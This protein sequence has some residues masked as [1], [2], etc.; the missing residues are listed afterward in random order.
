MKKY[1]VFRLLVV[2]VAALGLFAA[3][4]GSD[5]G[6]SRSN[7]GSV[8]VTNGSIY[9]IT[10]LYITL[11]SDPSW[12]SNRI[13]TSITSGSTRTISGLSPGTYDLWAVFSNGEDYEQY[14]FTV[15]S[16][17]T[18]PIT[19]T[20][21][22]GIN[23]G[24]V[25]V[26]NG[27]STYAITELYISPSSSS[28]WG[29]NQISSS[30]AVGSTRTI[31]GIPV[32]TYDLQAVFS[33][34]QTYTLTGFSVTANQTFAVTA[35]HSSTGGS[36]GTIT[37]RVIDALSRTALSNASY[38]VKQGTTT[39]ASGTTGSDGS[40]TAT[41]SA[42]TGYSVTITRTGYAQVV[43]SNITAEAGY[44]TYVEDI[45]QI[46]NTYATGTGTISGTISNAFDGTG[47]SGLTV[48]CVRA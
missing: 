32:G 23:T 45:P 34:A 48:G 28:T 3:G 26:T 13:T 1:L 17:G 8:A 35:V 14:G 36:S 15:T 2:L 22:S 16:G 4:C 11:S 12:G 29:S 5:G 31:T 40:Y 44:S 42:G 30:I 10:E 46:S 9:S 38:S 33:N 47:I 39:V 21:A 25:A 18:T 41:V 27:S 20:S 7:P 43:Y 37:G 24:S 19:A 6:S